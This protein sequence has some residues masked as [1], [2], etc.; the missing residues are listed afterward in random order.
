MSTDPEIC[1][2]VDAE[3]RV[4]AA[5]IPCRRR[6]P[7]M[8]TVSNARTHLAG[9]MASLQAHIFRLD[10]ALISSPPLV[11]DSASRRRARRSSLKKVRALSIGA[12]VLVDHCSEQGSAQAVSKLQ[13]RAGMHGRF[14]SA[15][16]VL[17]GTDHVRS[18]SPA[19]D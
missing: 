17:R 6:Q 11:A 19:F 2:A 3:L 15:G 16:F 4:T 9:R 10:V 18:R 8:L 7:V 13:K 14:W 12:C 1:V 5:R